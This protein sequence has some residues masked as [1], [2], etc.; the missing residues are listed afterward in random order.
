MPNPQIYGLIGYPVKH[1]LSPL[2]HNAAFAA[3]NINAEYRLFEISPDKLEEFLLTD[4]V[5]KDTQGNSLR[6]RDIIGF[7]ITIPHKVKSKEILEKNFPYAQ[8][9]RVEQDAYYVKLSG[10][11]NTVK[12]DGNRLLYWNTDS[13]GFLRSLE[14]DL[15]FEAQDK[16]IL[17]IGCGGAGRAVI[18]ALSW[19]NTE[20]DKIYVYDAN[21]SAVRAAKEHFSGL[22]QSYKGFAH[23][24]N[25]L[26]FI[27][28]NDIPQMIKRCHLLVNASPA[29][30][31]KLDGVIIDKNLLH[32]DLYVYDVVYNRKTQ[33]IK[34]AE[35]KGSHVKDGRGMLLFQ[36]ANA[37]ELWTGKSAPVEVMRQALER[38]LK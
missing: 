2:M 28:G 1:S 38:G 9:E 7:N 30:M 31:K 10:A 34:D 25:S 4:I 37:F 26:N 16:S 19:R 3:L 36:G 29:G 11:V 24:N 6:S 17:V 21:E 20:A 27:L 32:S 12:R 13:S 33:L 14:E 23:L 22:S 5:V 18:A 8:G 15:G 35:D